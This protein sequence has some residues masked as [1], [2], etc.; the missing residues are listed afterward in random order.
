M[1]QNRSAELEGCLRQTKRDDSSNSSGSENGEPE[2]SQVK[3]VQ[4]RLASS[5]EL[6]DDQPAVSERPKEAEESSGTSYNHLFG[7]PTPANVR[8]MK[9]KKMYEN[10]QQ[11]V[12]KSK[13]PLPVDPLTG[14]IIGNF[15][16]G[17]ASTSL[18]N[19]SVKERAD[20]VKTRK[21]W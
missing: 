11:L 7:P 13:K 5:F 12:R 6:G 16:D 21:L 20:K 3:K 19:Q 8:R 2:I 4:Y 10:D 1:E 17:I 14:N 9:I 18:N 15:D